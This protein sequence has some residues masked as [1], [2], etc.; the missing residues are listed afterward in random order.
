MEKSPYLP[1]VFLVL[2]IT[3]FSYIFPTF[4]SLSDIVLHILDPVLSE[5]VLFNHPCLP[6]V[7]PSTCQWSV[8]KYLGDCFLVFS[9]FGPRVYLRGSY[10][11]THV[12]PS[13]GPSVNISETVLRIFLI[14][15][16]VCTR[17]GPW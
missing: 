2:L 6:V 1:G 3:R 10:V 9:N 12:R 13:V 8:F 15:D 7:C 5:G 14:L 4:K 11:I 17:W 16:P